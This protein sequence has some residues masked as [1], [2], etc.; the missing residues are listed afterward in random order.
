MLLKEEK[1]T[2]NFGNESFTLSIGELSK[3]LL[4]F[5]EQDILEFEKEEV[6]ELI[7]IL[8]KYYERMD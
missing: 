2:T 4:F 3:R 7:D 5:T 6:A 1:F 8:Q